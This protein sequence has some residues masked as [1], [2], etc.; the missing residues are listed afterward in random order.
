MK[1]YPT[2]VRR[3]LIDLAGKIIHTGRRIILKVSQYIYERLNISLLWERCN[4]LLKK[5]TGF[6]RLNP[7]A[8]A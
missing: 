7:P 6:R 5:I 8:I 1:S 2:T 3:I 4:N